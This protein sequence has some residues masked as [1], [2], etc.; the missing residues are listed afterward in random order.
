MDPNVNSLNNFIVASLNIRGQTK[1]RLEKQR[2]IETFLQKYNCD[3]LHL[4]ESNIE[5]DTFKGCELITN[6]Y[7]II[8][9]NSQNRYGTASLVKTEYKVDNIRLDTEGRLIV[10]DVCDMT[11]VNIYLPSGTDSTSRAGRER[12]ISQ[13]LPNLISFSRD[14]AIIGGDFNCICE[15]EDATNNQEAKKSPTLRRVVKLRNWRD[16]FRTLHPKSKTFSHHYE[17]VKYEGASRLDRIYHQGDAHPVKVS[18]LPLAFSDH[19][20]ILAEFHVPANINKKL[21][22][23]F[24]A[25]FKIT[26]EIIKDV[27]FTANLIS[28]MQVWEKVLQDSSMPILKW[29]E[30]LVK[31]G[32]RSI[33]IA[34]KKSLNREKQGVLTLLQISQAYLT[35]KLQQGL[36]KQSEL[37][38]VHEQIEL[39]YKDDCERIKAQTNQD[40]F[41][42][43]ETTSL[44]HH[45]LLKKTFKKSQ[46]TKL[47]TDGGTLEGHK[48]CADFLV[49]QARDLLSKPAE[50]NIESQRF[51]LEE[52]EPVYTSEDNVKLLAAP[53]LKELKE[54]LARA[55]LHAAPGTDGIPSLLYKYHWEIMGSSL[56]KVISAIHEGNPLPRSLRTSMM[57]CGS[58]PKKANSLLPKDKRRISLLNA[59]FKLVTGTLYGRLKFSAGHTLSRNQYVGGDKQIQHAILLARDAIESAGTRPNQGCA[60]LD[61][62]LISAFDLMS[63]DWVT[64]VLEKKN[65]D[66]R[67]LSHLKNI[68]A[69]SVSEVVVN[70]KV[71]ATVDNKRQSIRQGDLPSMFLFCVGIDAVIHFLEKRLKG[72]KMCSR[73]VEG[74]TKF[75]FPRPNPVIQKYTVVGYA[76]DLKPSAD[77]VE[78]LI[79]IDKIMKK[80][81]EASGC[82]MHRTAASGK[83]KILRLGMWK[84]TMNRESIP[85]EY[86]TISESLDML[87]VKLTSCNSLTVRMNGEEAQKR[88]ENTVRIWSSGKFVSLYLRPLLVNSFCLSKIWYKTHSLQLRQSD[89]ASIESNC[90][91]YIYKGMLLKPEPEILYRPRAAGGLG[92]IDPTCKALACM[93]KTLIEC[94]DNPKYPPSSYLQLQLDKYITKKELLK[95]NHPPWLSE[96]LISEI[97]TQIENNPGKNIHDLKERGWYEAIIRRK[98]MTKTQEGPMAWIKCR[99]EKLEPGYD[100]LKNWKNLRHRHT[101]PHIASHLFALTHDLL[102]VEERL[103]KI[104]QLPSPKC[105]LCEEEEIG[106]RHHAFFDCSFNNGIGNSMLRGLADNTSPRDVLCLEF[107]DRHR[108]AV[109]VWGHLSLEL[110]NHRKDRRPPDPRQI[111]EFMEF[112]VSL[113]R[114]GDIETEELE[115]IEN[116]MKEVFACY[117]SSPAS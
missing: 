31:P 65:M 117:E 59:D 63:L 82:R 83:C 1:L 16:S 25:R 114:K 67:A 69:N 74:P 47:I 106:D 57:T 27:K 107:G 90:K 23:R 20:G 108:E 71:C 72:I 37:R 78:E 64:L 116:M 38:K 24:R 40:E 56:L 95:K 60:L 35:R 110:W 45:E 58:K 6:N 111:R 115:N 62:D 50:L 33:A 89:I 12:I 26:E 36:R 112:R 4:Q 91:K 66:K 98:L 9:N 41:L 68:Y 15:S 30:C 11:M 79:M 92:L 102:P 101:P 43:D 93:I 53:T 5:E 39:W 54:T 113:L 87:G 19:F 99:V 10:F 22:P 70:N 18:Y 75:L 97:S 51:L 17:N 100:W 103:A 46:I 105:T 7:D 52:I 85:L 2:Q 13:T 34:R 94:T 81:E 3:V 104:R 21:S 49:S 80:F 61:L 44:Y 8:S 32:I 14:I 77:S 48:D 88:V 84:K 96:R 109:W 28:N 76:D 73:P 42:E 55:N 86:L 29:W